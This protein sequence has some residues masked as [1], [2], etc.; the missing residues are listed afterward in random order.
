MDR[1]FLL[2]LLLVAYHWTAGAAVEGSN[3]SPESFSELDLSQ[4]TV[5]YLKGEDGGQDT[6]EC[7]QSQPFPLP[8]GS[9]QQRAPTPA[10][11]PCKSIGYSLLGNCLNQS[12]MTGCRANV[13]ENLAILVYPGKYQYGIQK[14]IKLFGYKNLVIRRLPACSEEVVFS[15]SSFTDLFYNNLYVVNSVNLSIDGIV[16]SD[17][18]P[19][20]PGAAIENVSNAILSNCIFR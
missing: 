11:T 17:C 18:G 15:C 9:C 7:L 19:K 16:F 13:T 3:L 1:N 14:T 12:H 10:I 6:E 4:Y 2:Y 5:R 8:P 20:S